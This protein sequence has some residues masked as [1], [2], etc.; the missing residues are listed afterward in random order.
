[1]PGI[2]CAVVVTIVLNGLVSTVF[3]VATQ[4]PIDFDLSGLAMGLGVGLGFALPLVSN[5]VPIQVFHCFHLL[6]KLFFTYS[7]IISERCRAHCAT[8]WTCII[9]R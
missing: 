7:A 1:V 6:A 2:F 8:R 9:R 5:I 3:G 4:F